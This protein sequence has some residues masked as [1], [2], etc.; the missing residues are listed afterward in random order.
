LIS[1]F[2]EED[3]KI[4]D[5]PEGGV[6]ALEVRTD[7]AAEV[8]AMPAAELEGVSTGVDEGVEISGGAGRVELEAD[9]TAGC[10]VDEDGK[11]ELMTAGVLDGSSAD[12]VEFKVA[13]GNPGTTG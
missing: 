4:L 11:T 13:E 2:A 5:L 1:K 6:A 12:V 10:G 8:G 3:G 7:G 9:G